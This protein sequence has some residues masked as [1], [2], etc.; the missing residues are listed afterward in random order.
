MQEI[1]RKKKKTIA[2]IIAFA[3]TIFLVSRINKDINKRN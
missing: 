1:F 2:Q 3:I